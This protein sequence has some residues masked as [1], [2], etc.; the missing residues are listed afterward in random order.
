MNSMQHA[1][2]YLVLMTTSYPNKRPIWRS[3]WLWALCERIFLECLRASVRSQASANG[4]HSHTPYVSMCL[5]WDPSSCFI[6]NPSISMQ[7]NI[8]QNKQ[9]NKSVPT[10]HQLLQVVKLSKLG[11]LCLAEGLAGCPVMWVFRKMKTF[12]SK[13]NPVARTSNINIFDWDLFY[14]SY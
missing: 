4:T 2:S 13:S 6:Y 3:S 5:G 14:C 7:Y 9:T 1:P 10:S 8:Q 11:L 12:L